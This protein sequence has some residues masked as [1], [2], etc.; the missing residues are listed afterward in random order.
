MVSLSKKKESNQTQDPHKG[1]SAGIKLSSIIEQELILCG[2]KARTKRDAVE[3]LSSFVVDRKPELSKEA[4]VE[5]VLVRER[6]CTTAIGRKSAFP[7]GKIAGLQ[8]MVVAIGISEVGV[9]FDAIDNAPVNFIVLILT[10]ETATGEYLGTLAALASLSRD[11]EKMAV[12]LRA[13]SPAEVLKTID[14]FDIMI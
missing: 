6:E 3:E 8:D 12:L 14:S 7:H 5:S 13:K 4:I 2:M 9:D 1:V 11:A 10:A